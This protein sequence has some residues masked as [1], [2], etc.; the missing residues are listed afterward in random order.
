MKGVAYAVNLDKYK[1]TGTL[2]VALYVNGER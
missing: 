1:L 2:W